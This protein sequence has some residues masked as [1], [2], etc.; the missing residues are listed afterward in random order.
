MQTVGRNKPIGDIFFLEN[1]SVVVVIEVEKSAGWI[2]AREM[3]LSSQVSS[4]HRGIRG[5]DCF[6]G[7]KTP[8][9]GERER[10]A[11]ANQR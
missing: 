2:C 7:G 11:A 4:A 8:S 6:C 5:E 3:D 9:E 1:R 10:P